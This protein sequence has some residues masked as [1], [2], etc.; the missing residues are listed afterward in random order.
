[1]NT[2]PPEQLIEQLKAARTTTEMANVVA[3]LLRVCGIFNYQR[4]AQELARMHVTSL[5]PMRG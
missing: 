5:G 4:V 2:Q 3:A 1:M